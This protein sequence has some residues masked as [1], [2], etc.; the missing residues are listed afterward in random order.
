MS[1][2]RIGYDETKK[3]LNKLRQLN[4]YNRPSKTLREQSEPQDTN[5]DTLSQKSTDNVKNDI[6]VINGVDIKMLS[7]DQMD[8][9]LTEEQ[10]TSISNLIDSFKQQ[11]TNLVDFKPGITM[12][13][14]QIRM[15]G[16]ITDFDF[17][18]TIAAGDDHGLYVNS[19]MTEVNQQLIDILTKL[20]KFF[21]IYTDS[22]N[23]IIDERK[24]N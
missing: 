22:M 16:S 10:K 3:M 5:G 21:Q 17:K 6:M 7:P 4:E 9:K 19:N 8:L 23:K 2:S 18:F 20:N 1:K 13:Q 24:N 15:D 12:N 14:N 11:V